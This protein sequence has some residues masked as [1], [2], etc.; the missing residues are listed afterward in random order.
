MPR[1]IGKGFEFTVSG[2][3]FFASRA[4]L[5]FKERNGLI[6]NDLMDPATLSALFSSSA[7]AVPVATVANSR[8]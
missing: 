5:K 3:I 7:M 4:A 6:V 1:V 8:K 2:A